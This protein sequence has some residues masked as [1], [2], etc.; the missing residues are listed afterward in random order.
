[1][2]FVFDASNYLE[3][4]GPG[5]LPLPVT[6]TVVISGTTSTVASVPAQTAV[7][8]ASVVVLAANAARKEC[9]FV[10]TGTTI[11]YLGL[12]QTPT[13]TA[14][15]IALLPCAVANDGSGGA[16]LSDIWKG[17]VNAI[18]SAAS[19]TLCITELT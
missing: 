1:V 4:T 17:A 9:I 8:T 15:H 6:G 7:G 14:Y 2:P 3:I 5:G 10:N 16:F 11:I 13:V 18:G 12:G 19:G